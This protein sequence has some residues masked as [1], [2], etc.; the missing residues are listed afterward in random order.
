MTDNTNLDRL[1]RLDPLDVGTTDELDPDGTTGRRVRAAA[2]SAAQQPGLGAH[3]TTIARR[4]PG[5]GRPFAA[6]DEARLELWL[7]RGRRQGILALRRRPLRARQEP[8][9]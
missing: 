3:G 1:R 9:R 2:I 5:R 6:D 4:A 8:T 7:P